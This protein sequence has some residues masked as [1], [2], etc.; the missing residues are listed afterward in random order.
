MD[1]LSTQKWLQIFFEMGGNPSEEMSRL[2]H[3]CRETGRKFDAE[4]AAL[5]RSVISQK[6]RSGQWDFDTLLASLS[7]AAPDSQTAEYLAIE[8]EY[9]K[10]VRTEILDLALSRKLSQIESF[11]KNH[12]LA[13]PS[14]FGEI[15]KLALST[16]DFATALTKIQKAYGL[17]PDFSFWIRHQSL[18]GR[19][20]Q[21]AP[22]NLFR[23][24]MRLGLIGSCTTSFL[25]HF[26]RSSAL[27]RG[28]RLEIYEGAFGNY[29]QEIIDPN[30]GLYRFNPDAVFLLLESH[31][32]HPEQTVSERHIREYANRILRLRD[33]F[34][35]NSSAH[36]IQTGLEIPSDTSWGNLE[37]AKEDGRIR[38]LEQLNLMMSENLREGNSFLYPS[39]LALLHPGSWT[40]RRDWFVARQY[41]APKALPVLADAVTSILAASVG[42]NKKVLVLDLDNTCWGGVIGRDGFAG[43]KIGQGFSEGES[44]TS[45][46]QYA[47]ELQ[48]K[49]VLLCA[50]SKNN[51]ADALLPFTKLSEMILKREDFVVFQANW[52][53]KATNL[54]SIAKELSLSLD[55]FVFVDDNPFERALVRNRLPEVT[56]P[57]F[58]NL[59]WKIVPTLRRGMYFETCSLTDEDRKRHEHYRIRN[60]IVTH[61][62]ETHDDF[63][64]SLNMKAKAIQI[65]SSNLTRVTQLLNRSNQFNATTKRFTANE[66][67]RIVNSN[68]WWCRAFSLSDSFENHGIVGVLFA[69]A[70]QSTWTI[71]SLVMSCRVIGRRL[72]DFMLSAVMEA[73]ILA[74]A[75]EIR[76]LY[77][78]T[79]K[80]DLVRS[81]YESH[82]F[83][84]F[85]K[86][87]NWRFKLSRGSVPVCDVI[88]SDTD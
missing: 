10:N 71:D 34:H 67:Q 8:L 5:L 40:S 62:F 69:Q 35:E 19:L 74:D 28:I 25:A 47:K 3:L 59:H 66:V 78:P 16:G 12:G 72:E 9:E 18:T 37:Y 51:E 20:L 45:L 65:N 24:E 46:Q 73:A 29:N 50:C 43:I 76:G 60:Q 23:R 27:A 79:S 49:G 7:H 81:F 70:E 85:D 63:L 87:H 13:I 55:S 56:V 32:F 39:Q 53:D 88:S 82:G 1:G 22:R 83:T 30:S 31:D 6:T 86:M 26:L 48:R 36:F 44:F 84:S 58:D 54:V 77:V 33:V 80:N 15:A 75:A 41:P 4:L 42:L 2:L 14:I 68:D 11:E 17:F 52:N 38:R 57:E 61:C 21:E 64:G